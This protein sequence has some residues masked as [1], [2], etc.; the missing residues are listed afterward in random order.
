MSGMDGVEWH[1]PTG[2]VWAEEWRRTD[3]TFAEI[4][5]ELD[6]AVR[7]RLGTGAMAV[8]DIGCGAGATS[9]AAAR[10]NPQASVTGFDISPGLVAVARERAAGLPNCRFLV[11][12]AEQEIAS[13]GPFDMLISRHGVMFFDDPGMAFASLRA[14]TRPGASLVFSCFRASALNLWASEV[15][16]AIFGKLPP[17][18]DGYE[19][20][21][22]AFADEGFV[23]P[24]LEAS[25]WTDVEVL[26]VDFTYHAGVGEDPVADAVS[27]F[28]RIGPAARA[29]R[30]AEPEDR[31]AMIERIAAVCRSRVV[32]GEVV[33]PA[34]AWLWS[35][36]NPG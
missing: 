36:R 12:P 26:P 20:G 27:F 4:S 18:P 34:A 14:A 15:M 16:T 5:S 33:F 23:R 32:G 3:R 22:F 30:V 17:K 28:S 31:A 24:M 21:P 7:E 9:M 13:H 19:P 11:G 1:G 2:D 10:A 6:Q 25:G 35:A 8:A 29:L